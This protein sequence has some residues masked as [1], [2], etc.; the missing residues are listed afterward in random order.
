M[1]IFVRSRS[2]DIRHVA[3]ISRT[4]SAEAGGRKKRERGRDMSVL[5]HADQEEMH[6]MDTSH[7][8]VA[9]IGVDQQKW[10][11]KVRAHLAEHLVTLGWPQRPPKATK[12]RQDRIPRVPRQQRP[13][14]VAVNGKRT[15]PVNGERATP[16]KGGDPMNGDR[17]TPMN[18]DRKVP[19]RPVAARA[20]A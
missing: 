8:W 20:V 13:A 18:G 14:P 11:A 6:Y 3:V 1:S 5:G 9:P 7:R 10:E 16:V 15:T 2:P 12:A 19:A 17:M 4:P